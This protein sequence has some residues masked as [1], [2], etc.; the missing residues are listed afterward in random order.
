MYKVDRQFKLISVSSC[1]YHK[2]LNMSHSFT[3]E[4]CT[5]SSLDYTLILFVLEFS[6][7]VFFL[8]QWYSIFRFAPFN[9]YYP[10]EETICMVIFI[11]FIVTGKY[12]KFI[13]NILMV[14][15][16]KLFLWK[17]M[18]WF[19]CIKPSIYPLF[20]QTLLCLNYSRD[21]LAWDA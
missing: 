7:K 21:T 17:L 18:S 6:Y 13:R 5:Y 19:S 4:C 15:Y 12:S 10:K 9:L 16:I 14:L 8:L 2:C 11:F 1:L 3:I 20:P